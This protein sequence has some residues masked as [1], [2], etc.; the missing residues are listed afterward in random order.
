MPGSAGV[1]PYLVGKKYE[2]E[3][4]RRIKRSRIFVM[5]SPGS[6]RRSR[7]TWLPDI[8]AIS[9]SRVLF[10]ESKYFS[11][12]RHV[13]IPMASVKKRLY[14]RDLAGAVFYICVFFEEVGDFRCIDIED[15][16]WLTTR[17]AVYSHKDLS[18][19]G[20]TVEQMIKKIF[21]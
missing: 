10:I 7:S 17:Y 14:I 1:R 12:K 20:L 19:K 16:S 15:V 9:R 13:S 8:V 5:R 2:L 11:K 4:V 6:G 21:S 18:E 3:L